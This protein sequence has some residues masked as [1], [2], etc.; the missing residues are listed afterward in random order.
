MSATPDFI[1]GNSTTRHRWGEQPLVPYTDE[2]YNQWVHRYASLE[3]LGRQFLISAIE[4]VRSV[5][6]ESAMINEE[7]EESLNGQESS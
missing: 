4:V 3:F 6:E 1:P 2:Q 7:M 5:S